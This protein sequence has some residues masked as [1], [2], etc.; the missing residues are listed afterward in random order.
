MKLKYSKLTVFLL[1]ASLGFVGCKEEDKAQ[2]NRM[3]TIS[4]EGDTKTITGTVNED[5]TLEN[6]FTWKL[7]GGI[8]VADGYTLTVE[9]GTTI[10]SAADGTTA[11]L[12]VQR[13]GKIMA[14]GTASNPIVFTSGE[15][16]PSSGDWGGIIVN[17]KAP[18]NTGAT[19]EGEGGTGIYGGT[20]GSDNSGVIRYVRVEYAGKILGTDNELN[21]FSFNGVGSGTTVEYVQAYNGSDDGF[22]FFGGTVNVRYAVSSGNEDDSFDWTHGWSGKGQFWVV[23]QFATGGDRGI[24]AD[25]NGDDNTAAPYS[26]PTLSNITLIGIQDSDSDNTGMRLREGTKGKIYNAIVT[27]FPKNGIRVSDPITTANMTAGDLMV[28][29]SVSFN[30]GT[31]WKD[32]AEFENDASNNSNAVVLNG[33]VGTTTG[34]MDVSTSDSWFVSTN[35]IGAVETSND[36]TAGWIK[37]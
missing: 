25:N 35:F 10:K 33:F 19:A 26:N 6:D 23:N 31:D 34:G 11:F 22:E 8:F 13:G 17:G 28:S 32:C 24:E 7:S 21:G 20:N 15:A 2:D 37:N 9:E 30:N 12:A 3:Y 14:N 36:W 27:N 5:L 18:I 16:N 1:S 29:N 4:T